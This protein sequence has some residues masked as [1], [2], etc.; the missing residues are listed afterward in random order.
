MRTGLLRNV[1]F[2]SAHLLV[3]GMPLATAQA[4]LEAAVAAGAGRLDTAP[5]YGHGGCEA[6]VA[7]V[8]AA[9]AATGMAVPVTT[10]VGLEPVAPPSPWRAAASA[11]LRRLPPHTVAAVRRWLGRGDA[12][13]PL[14]TA[15]SGRF[16]CAAVQRS[17]ERS[18]SRLGRIDRL[19][20]H[21]VHL[22]DITDE[23]LQLLAGYRSRGD[24]AVLG[25]AT[26][27]AVTLAALQLGAGL[28]SVAHISVD[29]LG[30]HLPQLLAQVKALPGVRV[31]GHGALGAGGRALQHVGRRLQ[32]DQGLAERWSAAVQGT[33]FAGPEGIASALLARA[34]ATGVAELLVSTRRLPRV[35]PLLQAAAASQPLPPLAAGV[36]D[37]LLRQPMTRQ[38]FFKT[39][40]P[41]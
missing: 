40:G 7:A 37:D 10:K 8:A 29:P 32:A 17:I 9:A 12:A 16:G 41:T 13:A 19:L 34:A 31:V 11:A 6:L 23:L 39:T 15:P 30:A 21:E 1:A 20:L 35:A 3:G 36:L 25:I 14:Q 27:N 33:P 24:V 22:A 5:L 38:A 26:G 28:F 2:G 18:L 4:L